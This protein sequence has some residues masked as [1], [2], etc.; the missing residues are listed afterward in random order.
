MVVVQVRQ[1][2]ELQISDY[3][4]IILLMSQLLQS[5]PLNNLIV[6][7]RRASLLENSH[8]HSQYRVRLVL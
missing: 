6:G 3:Q 4:L 1:L 8:K 5:D 2:V 7:Q